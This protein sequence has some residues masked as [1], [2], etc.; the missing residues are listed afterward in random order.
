VLN[1]FAIVPEHFI[2]ATAA[3]A[4]QTG[5]LAADDLAAT[6]ACITAYK[7]AGA[8]LFAFFNSGDH[9]GASQP[10][11][12]IQLL[13]VQR[14]RDGLDSHEWSVLADRAPELNGRLPFRI[15]ARAVD[16]HM[17]AG[18][19]RD[20]Y[21]ELYREACTACGIEDVKEGHDGVTDQQ[22]SISYNLAMT[23]RVM[24]LCPR[25]AEGAPLRNANGEEVG[26]LALNGTVLAGTALVKSEADWDTL[27]GDPKQLEDVLGLIGLSTAKDHT[28]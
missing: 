7:C 23:S 17:T 12:H 9:S 1:K 21:L 20:V 2:L 3:F 5:L 19:L 22:A 14:M 16:E 4:P 11:R 25:L 24:V 27:R 13:P 28:S 18:H 8:E 26:K 15:F 10:H 6:M